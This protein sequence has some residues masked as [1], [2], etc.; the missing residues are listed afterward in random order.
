MNRDASQL[1]ALI[2]AQHAEDIR[3]ARVYET[4]EWR[5]GG[6]TAPKL[7]GQPCTPSVDTSPDALLASSAPTPWIVRV[8]KRGSKHHIID[9]AGREVCTVLTGESDAFLI[10]AAVNVYRDL[11]DYAASSDAIIAAQ[12]AEIARLEQRCEVQ[13]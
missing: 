9:D 4:G 7:P 6:V 10:T 3:P 13:P 1:K 11:L 8:S 12:R 2:D 5:F